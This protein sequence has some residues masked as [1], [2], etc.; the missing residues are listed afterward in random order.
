MP[1]LAHSPNSSVQICPTTNWQNPSLRF[2]SVVNSMG[3]KYPVFDF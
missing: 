2:T 3:T 1:V